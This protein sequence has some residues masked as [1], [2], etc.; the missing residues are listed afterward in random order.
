MGQA[1]T[2][3]LESNVMVVHPCVFS[4][5]FLFRQSREDLRRPKAFTHD[6]LALHRTGCCTAKQKH[7]SSMH[8][9]S[10]MRGAGALPL[11]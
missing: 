8:P 5:S 2:V 6:L 9:T 11:K 3:E 4:P 1:W 7:A 10:T